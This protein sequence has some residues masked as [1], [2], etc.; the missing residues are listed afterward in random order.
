MY[1]QLSGMTWWCHVMCT[2][3]LST[4]VESSL[5]SEWTKVEVSSE[6]PGE[7]FS[8]C[9]QMA[10]TKSQMTSVSIWII[11][12]LF[13]CFYSIFPTAISLT[14]PGYIYKSFD[15]TGGMTVL[16]EGQSGTRARVWYTLTLTVKVCWIIYRNVPKY[17]YC[18]AFPLFQVNPLCLESHFATLSDLYL[19]WYVIYSVFRETM[20]QQISTDIPC[21]RMQC[22][23]SHEM[24]GR[25]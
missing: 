19:C 24:D 2:W 20:R 23:G 14:K 8:G 10:P 4:P 18:W 12:A 9:M 16:A 15:R 1:L 3:K 22:S 13:F 6:A 21:G 7:S 5:L 11:K 25:P 17:I